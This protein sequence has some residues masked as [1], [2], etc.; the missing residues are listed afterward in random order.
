MASDGGAGSHHPDPE[1]G[2]NPHRVTRTDTDDTPPSRRHQSFSVRYLA[3]TLWAYLVWNLLTWTATVENLA[4]GLGVCLAAAA[5]IAA[6]GTVVPPWR[7]LEPRR[8]AG[9]LWLSAVVL[10]GIVRENVRLARRICLPSRPIASGM[11]IAPTDA[12]TDGEVAAVGLITSLV[13]DNQIIDVDRARHL[14]QFHGVALP[15]PGP[16]HARE[17]INGPVERPLLFL[18]RR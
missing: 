3:A 16:Q 9:A 8:L 13:V 14:L 12:R 6:A 10:A 5:A 17:A 7:L 2:S 1:V 15:P 4:V 11:V 18:S